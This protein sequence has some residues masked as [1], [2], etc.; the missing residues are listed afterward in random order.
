M[1]MEVEEYPTSPA[2][3][4]APIRVNAINSDRARMAE[5]VFIFFPFI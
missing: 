2:F 3:A 4:A 5:F 1:P